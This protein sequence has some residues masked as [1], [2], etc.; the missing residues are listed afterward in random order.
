MTSGGIRLWAAAGDAARP[1]SKTVAD[2]RYAKRFIG[3][4]LV[5]CARKPSVTVVRE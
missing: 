3:L 4:A 2:V 1:S 5:P